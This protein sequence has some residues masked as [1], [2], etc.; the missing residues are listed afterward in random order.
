MGLLEKRMNSGKSEDGLPEYSLKKFGNN[1]KKVDIPAKVFFPIFAALV[2]IA[3]IYVTPLVM[4]DTDVRAM[5]SLPVQADSSALV[6]AKTVLANN[7]DADF[8]GDGLTN[9]QEA[10]HGTLPYFADSDGDGV[11]DYAELYLTE[12]NPKIA[13]KNLLIEITKENDMVNGKS[14]NSPIKVHNVIIWPDDYASRARGGVVKTLDGYRFTNFKGWAQ[15]PETA[16]YGGV[17]YAEINGYN[18]P[19]KQNSQGYYRI[20]MG[21]NVSIRIHNGE[22]EMTNELTLFGHKFYIDNWVG[23]ALAAILP[24]KGHG[25]LICRTMAK[26]DIEGRERRD[27]AVLAEIV[28]PESV[29]LPEY[30][31]ARN[32][33]SLVDLGEVVRI[34]G[35]GECVVAS[36]YSPAQGEALVLVYGYTYYGNLL[37]ADIYD[38]SKLGAL[39]VME[40]ATRQF[41]KTGETQQREWFSFKG[42][43]FNSDNGD[44]IVFLTGL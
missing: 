10:L 3:A 12:T 25:P 8:D 44:R 2:L 42:C 14:V 19:L 41:D 33:N 29:S 18:V 40:R 23:K 13:D 6:A 37:V 9:E 26:I 36:L 30:R 28:V 20:D 38:G 15:F 5:P 34:L 27:A 35:N 16:S 17:P 11:T 24:S 32:Q 7:P 39:N 22:L 31:F 4:P 21:A 1:K 43:G